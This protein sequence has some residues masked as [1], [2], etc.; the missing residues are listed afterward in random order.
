MKRGNHKL[1]NRI[2]KN[3]LISKEGRSGERD[4][5]KRIKGIVIALSLLSKFKICSENHMSSQKLD[6]LI[7]ELP[8]MLTSN[9]IL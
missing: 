9:F 7:P 2:I 3:T 1:L 5:S 8:D 6:Q 4:K